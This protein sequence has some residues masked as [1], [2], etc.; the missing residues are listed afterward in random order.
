MIKP[1]VLLKLRCC[2]DEMCLCVWKE[3]LKEREIMLAY[4]E[5]GVR[6]EIWKE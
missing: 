6:P 3:E 4:L 1:R 5:T 2:L